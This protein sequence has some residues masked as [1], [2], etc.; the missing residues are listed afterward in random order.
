VSDQL[1]IDA[2]TVNARGEEARRLVA[3]ANACAGI[4]TAALEAGI[5]QALLADLVAFYEEPGKM[6]DCE[7]EMFLLE[8]LGF[9]GGAAAECC[10]RAAA[11][12]AGPGGVA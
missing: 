2:V 7:R 4:P 5:L 1:W 12:D 6:V 11:I 3:C 9:L 10:A 8:R